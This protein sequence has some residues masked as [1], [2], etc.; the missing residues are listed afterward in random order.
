M[1]LSSSTENENNSNNNNPNI[2][3]TKQQQQQQSTFR[4]FFKWFGKCQWMIYSTARTPMCFYPKTMEKVRNICRQAT[5]IEHWDRILVLSDDL[6]DEMEEFTKICTTTVRN[7][8]YPVPEDQVRRIWSDA[9]R[10]AI[11]AFHDGILEK[12]GICRHGVITRYESQ[13][14]EMNFSTQNETFNDVPMIIMELFAGFLAFQHLPHATT[15]V[16]DNI[17]AT[18][19]IIRGHSGNQVCDAILRQWIKSGKFPRIVEWVD[20]NCMLADPISRP[21]DN[22][23]ACLKKC[24]SEHTSTHIRWKKTT[25]NTK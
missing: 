19:A 24:S 6:V 10:S 7:Y 14:T 2:I 15:W 21:D 13:N 1:F 22:L 23:T 5:S 4:H 25:T 11:A 20:T 9:S 17:P 16:S 12:T 8:D 18:R 3:Q